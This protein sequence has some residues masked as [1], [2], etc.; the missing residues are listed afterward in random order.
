MMEEISIMF[1][2]AVPITFEDAPTD[3]YATKG[4]DYKVKCRVKADPVPQVDWKKDHRAINDTGEF[5]NPDIVHFHFVCTKW[6]SESLV[7]CKFNCIFG[8]HVA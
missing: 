8:L 2:F 5:C 4:T 1:C 3:Q 6:M 7:S